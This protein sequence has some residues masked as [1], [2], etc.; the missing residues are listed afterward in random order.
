MIP[1]EASVSASEN[2][3]PHVSERE[4]LAVF[5]L[6]T[7]ISHDT[8]ETVQYVIV[9]LD[10]VFPEDRG[11]LTNELNH[12]LRSG[13]YIELARAQGVELLVRRST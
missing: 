3:N 9:D 11:P 7:Y 4:R 5:P 2:I 6:I 10:A 8:L 13:Q 1:P 12:L